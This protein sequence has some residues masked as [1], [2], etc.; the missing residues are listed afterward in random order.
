VLGRIAAPHGVKGWVKIAPFTAAPGALAEHRRWWLGRDGEWTEV[1]VAE[2]HVRGGKLVAR[3]TGCTDRDAAGRLRGREIAVPRDVLPEAGPGEYY[4]ADLVGLEVVNREGA[5]LGRV[6]N[7][8]STGA[9]DVLRV[10]EGRRERLLPFV[11]T[12]IRRV[13]LAG[14]RIE[15]DWGLDW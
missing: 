12:V 14:R 13:D 10:G 8:F 5:S 3:V 6:T 7:V 1:E 15:V 11:A 2:A 4:W 9:N